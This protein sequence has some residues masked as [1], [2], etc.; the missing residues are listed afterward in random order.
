LSLNVYNNSM[1]TNTRPCRKL[2]RGQVPIYIM[3]Q[4][5][6][7]FDLSVLIH[8]YVELM[9]T[10]VTYEQTVHTSGSNTMP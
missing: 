8:H 3:L 2:N 10:L 6:L 1:G 9:Y 4:V 7:G 5:Y